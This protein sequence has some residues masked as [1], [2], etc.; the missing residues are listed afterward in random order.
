[1]TLFG[2]PDCELYLNQLA[3]E[4]EESKRFVNTSS[5]STS[6]QSPSSSSQ[7]ANLRKKFR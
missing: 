3:A 4:I 5:T 1:M 7:K 6:P 2:D